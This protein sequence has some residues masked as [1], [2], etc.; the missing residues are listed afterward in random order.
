MSKMEGRKEDKDWG[1]KETNHYS[2][3]IIGLRMW[4]AKKLLKKSLESRRAFSKIIGYKNNVHKSFCLS[5]HQ[6]QIIKI[7]K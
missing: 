7:E 4:K 3:Q 6:P 2:L 1:K 5:I